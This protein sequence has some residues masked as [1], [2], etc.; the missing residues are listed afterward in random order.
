MEPGQI[1]AERVS[2]RFRVNPHRNL[3]LK[4][5]VLRPET[6]R[7]EEIWA[8][9]DVSLEIE[10]GASVGFVGRIGSGKTTFL[11][12]IAG[13]FVPTSGRLEIGGAIGGPPAAA[14]RL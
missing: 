14:G 5:A 7:A 3:T 6:R 2:R 13:I 8:L 4:E 1:V 9:R 10:P 12:L 11:R